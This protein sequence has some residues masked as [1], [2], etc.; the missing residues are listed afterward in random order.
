VLNN[1]DLHMYGQANAQNIVT[2]VANAA[3]NNSLPENFLNTDSL[4]SRL[5]LMKFGPSK[6]YHYTL[7]IADNKEKNTKSC[8][9]T[10]DSMSRG[11]KNINVALNPSQQSQP[12]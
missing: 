8:N 12:P 5:T 11:Q 7:S 1:K 6:H 3:N 10:S 4:L 9:N 2:N